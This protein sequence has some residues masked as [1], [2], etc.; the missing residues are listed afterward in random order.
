MG[1]QLC[2]RGGSDS[3]L[4]SKEQGDT[5][6]ERD[7][8]MI[9]NKEAGLDIDF[10]ADDLKILAELVKKMREQMVT[11]DNNI[12]AAQILNTDIFDQAVVW[13]DE[14]FEMMQELRQTVDTIEE[15]V[16]AEYWPIPTYIDL[17][18]GI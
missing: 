15:S 2:E 6:V 1:N 11:L 7:L 8:K 13:R 14:V 4:V 17:L 16:D 3:R 10:L 18:F 5:K 12:S 9:T